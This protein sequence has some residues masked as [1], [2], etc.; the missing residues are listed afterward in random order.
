MEQHF[1]QIVEEH[2]K[3][4]RQDKEIEYVIVSLHSAGLTILDSIKAIRILYGVTLGAAKQL[5]TSNPV[6]NDMVQRNKPFQ[7]ELVRLVENWTDSEDE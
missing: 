1:E 5:V 4:V 6:W 2:R 7:E 3:L